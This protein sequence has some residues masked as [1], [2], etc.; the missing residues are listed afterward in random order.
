[1]FPFFQVCDGIVRSKLPIFDH[2]KRA[3]RGVRL[4]FDQQG[5]VQSKL[6]IFDGPP[7]SIAAAAALS[8]NAKKIAERRLTMLAT[9]NATKLKPKIDE[10]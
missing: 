2:T 3:P 1:L 4:P 9:A 5:F 7:A 8:G 10:I 6:A